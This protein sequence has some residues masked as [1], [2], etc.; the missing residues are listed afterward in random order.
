MENFEFYNP[1]RI[2]FGKGQ[3]ENLGSLIRANGGTKV[4]VH[5]GGKSVKETGILSKVLNCLKESGISYVEVGGVIPNPRLSLCLDGA[6]IA[7]KEKCDFILAVGGGSVI[8]SAKCLAC[9]VYD[10]NIWES[11]MNGNRTVNKALPIGVVLTIPAAGSE[12]SNGAVITN[13]NQKLKRDFCCEVMYPKFSIVD[14]EMTYTL[15]NNQIAY[16]ATDILAHMMERY[17]TPTKVCDFTNSILEGAMK[18]HIENSLRVFENKENYDIR[19]EMSLSAILAHNNALAVGRIGDWASHCIEH[20]LSAIND[21]AHGA[22][23]A[24]IFPAWMKY[25]HT[26]NVGT[27]LFARFARE[28]FGVDGSKSENEMIETG[29]Q[30]LEEYYKKLGLATRLCEVGIERK[31]FKKI[32]KNAVLNRGTIGNLMKLTADDVYQILLLAEK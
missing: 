28:V 8:D 30:K 29:I 22:G 26:K 32:A 21:I 1:T 24:I 18:A 27:K 23:L 31:H 2:V 11:F 14:P 15:P 19:A 9:A 20:E 25:L 7:R 10:E 5:F 6:E 3:L 13:E 4:L 12:S 17:F 16:G